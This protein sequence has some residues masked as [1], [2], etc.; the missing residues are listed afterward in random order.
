[1]PKKI[2]FESAVHQLFVAADRFRTNLQ[3]TSPSAAARFAEWVRQ[4]EVGY[5]GSTFRVSWTKPRPGTLVVPLSEVRFYVRGDRASASST[6][7]YDDWTGDDLPQKDL[8]E[9]ANAE[10]F[11]RQLAC[12]IAEAGLFHAEAAVTP[13]PLVPPSASVSAD[14]ARKAAEAEF[15][16]AWA[17]GVDP[18][19]IN[20]RVM[21]EACTAPEMRY[22]RSQLGDIRGQRL[23]DVGCGLG[24]A[25]VY[26]A[27][28]GA[29]VTASDISQGMLD[30]TCRLADA[31]GVVV[32]TKLSASEDLGLRTDEPFDIIYTGNTLHHVDIGQTLNH[33]LPLLKPDGV[34]VSWD[35]L[36]YNPVINVYRWMATEVR[37]VDEHPLRMADLRLMKSRF[38]SSKTRYFWLLTLVIFLIMALVQRRSPNKERYWK[39]VVEEADAWSWLYRPLEMADGLLLT[40]F[41]FLRPL[42]WNVV[43][44]GR[45]P[46]RAANSS[47]RC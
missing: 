3:R 12:I 27:M 39:K 45:R 6:G 23:L 13:S 30:A 7:A 18:R 24:E 29:R 22:I 5:P 33:L 26:F 14:E 31:N 16:D 21:N 35:P 25:S 43:F 36:A 15:H 42:C 37:T 4:I 46:L 47:A 8:V 44:V 28:E 11:D 1:M 41:P 34:F 19:T 40:I 9:S 20:V 32:K 17:A 2:R 10:F 38:Q